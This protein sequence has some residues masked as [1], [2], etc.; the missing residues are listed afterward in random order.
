MK[1]AGN[2]LGSIAQHIY[3]GMPAEL[4][5]SIETE[6][7]GKPCPAFSC[8]NTGALSQRI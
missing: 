6:E 7:P 1:K 2:R 8:E 3:A 4:N 5:L